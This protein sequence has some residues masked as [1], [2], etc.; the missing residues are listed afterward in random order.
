MTTVHDLLL[1]E[2]ELG[3]PEEQIFGF[4]R[5]TPLIP[6]TLSL[7]VYQVDHTF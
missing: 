5:H 4:C 7:V 6:V 3:F 1:P 2:Y